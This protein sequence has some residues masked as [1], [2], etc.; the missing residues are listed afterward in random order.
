MRAGI[1]HG[2]QA[3]GAQLKMT[4]ALNVTIIMLEHIHMSMRIIHALN[5]Q[6]KDEHMTK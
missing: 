1:Q 6:K 4:N 2:K 3:N 5:C